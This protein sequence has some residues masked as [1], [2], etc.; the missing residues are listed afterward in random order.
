[1]IRRINSNVAYERISQFLVSLTPGEDHSLHIKL[2]CWNLYSVVSYEELESGTFSITF[3]DHS[4]LNVQCDTGSEAKELRQYLNNPTGEAGMPIHGTIPINLQQAEA[5]L[6]Q[7]KAKD[8]RCKTRILVTVVCVLLL[9]ALI[10]REFSSLPQ[11]VGVR[12]LLETLGGIVFPLGAVGAS[13]YAMMLNHRKLDRY[14][15]CDK[16][17]K[18]YESLVK[19]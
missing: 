18:Y 15:N 1:M 8:N 12:D 3:S 5:I 9:G 19:G 14:L 6:S 17:K 7:R 16:E 11:L 13:L 2:L 4:V 10:G